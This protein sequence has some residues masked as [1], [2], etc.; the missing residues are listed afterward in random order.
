VREKVPEARA[1]RLDVVEGEV[2]TNDSSSSSSSS[3]MLR[4]ELA[5]AL[6]P[7][8]RSDEAAFARSFVMAYCSESM[9]VL[10]SMN[11]L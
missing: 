6:R 11:I 7:D 8:R 4:R 5:A 1:E 10:L 2:S 3:A 9:S